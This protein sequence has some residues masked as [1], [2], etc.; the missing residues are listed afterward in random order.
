M[1]AQALRGH[2]L[3]ALA[4]RRD[5]KWGY[6]SHCAQ[7]RSK[8]LLNNTGI[9]MT[10]VG[11]IL[12]VVGGLVSAAAFFNGFQDEGYAIQFATTV[13]VFFLC[14]MGGFDDGAK[15]MRNAYRL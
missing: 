8:D 4:L 14:S 1:L 6:A 5:A 9:K 2:H 15:S 7:L 3:P 11:R 13:A 12:F 10:A